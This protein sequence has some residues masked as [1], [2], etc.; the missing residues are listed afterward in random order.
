MGDVATVLQA[1]EEA[2]DGVQ[3][4]TPADDEDE[5]VE[6]VE[7]GTIGSIKHFDHPDTIEDEP[8]SGD[9]QSSAE[10]IV[11][12]GNV[13]DIAEEEL[14]EEAENEVSADFNRKYC[15]HPT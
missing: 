4:S 14:E 12:S 3:L 11:G 15:V 9:P 6:E 13:A 1:E 5:G 8:F 10:T 2:L 7:D